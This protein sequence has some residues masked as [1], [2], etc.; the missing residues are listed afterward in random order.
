MRFLWELKR[1]HVPTPKVYLRTP[2]MKEESEKYNWKEGEVRIW[3]CNM[4][5]KEMNLLIQLRCEVAK[6]TEKK[7]PESNC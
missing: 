3:S 6:A 4:L 5:I 7:N 1:L 2:G